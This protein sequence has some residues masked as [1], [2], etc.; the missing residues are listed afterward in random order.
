M[1][2]RNSDGSWADPG[3]GWTEGDAWIYT[4]DVL[5]DIPGLVQMLGGR[6][7]FDARL[8]AYFAGRHNRHGNE[9]SHHVGYL[10]D[11]GGEPWKTQSVVRRLAAAEYLN[12]PGG[13]DGDDDC[14]QMSAWYIFTALGFYPVNPASGEFMIG[15]PLFSRASLRLGGG[16]VFTVVA[17]GNSARNL[18]IQS[19]TLDGRP[20][21]VPVLRL[22]DITR[23]ATLRLTMG[24]RP[25]RWGSGYDP[26]P[27]P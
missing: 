5:H 25:S 26:K 18:Y 12:E 19:A 16:R 15:S 3:N 10:Y 6:Q 24:P 23:G 7:A 21:D 14:G 9:P 2:A 27:L 8:D 20:L 17:D 13:L 1:R 4:W 11:F 22:E